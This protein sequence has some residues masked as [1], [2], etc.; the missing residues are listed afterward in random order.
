MKNLK[1]ILLTVL[2]AMSISLFAQDKT[3]KNTNT[4]DSVLVKKGEYYCPMHPDVKSKHA[5]KC[6]RCGTPLNLSVKEQMKYAD[7]KLYSCPMHPNERS[8]KPGKCTKC[9]MSLTKKEQ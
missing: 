7:M 5:S 8:S 1:L 3:E 9:G 4:Q 6:S 2:T